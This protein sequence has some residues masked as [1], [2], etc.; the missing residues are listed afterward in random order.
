[1]KKLALFVLLA[2]SPAF[3]QIGPEPTGQIGTLPASY[4]GHWV[5]LQDGAFFHMNNGKIIVVDAD[6]DDPAT[7][8]K[9]MFDASFIAQM[10]Q[11]RT[12][13][14]IYIAE[15]FYSRGT[16]GERTDV[17]TIYDKVNLSPSG[18]VVIPPKRISGMPTYYHLQAVDNERLLLAYNFTPA[19][20]V[21]VVDIDS[22]EFLGEIPIPGCSLI[23][24]MA[25]RAFASLC[26]DG[27]MMSVQL[28]EN[29]AQASSART[30]VFFDANND[31]LMEKAA[32][33]DSVAY[34]PSF[35]GRVVPV[36]LSGDEP[37]VG[38]EWSLIGDEEGGWR[39]GGLAVTGTDA[40]GRMYVLMHPEGYEGS[41]K[42]PGVE[43]WVFDVGSRQRVD[44]IALDLPAISIGITQ[45]DDPLLLAT[46]INLEVDVYDVA[47]GAHQRTLSGTGAQTP[48]LLHGG[49]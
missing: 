31:P 16:R 4:P 49:L 9:G 44:R 8:V 40:A 10:Y 37:V 3:G 20:S 13:S 2:A 46:N 25:G 47:S 27:T 24:P 6:S 41:H 39:P 11:A 30:D 29:G 22:R 5:L 36:D 34:F 32:M 17:I 42:D 7:R 14:E 18:E 12:K 1:M 43:V 28:D 48:F 38:D 19:T 26:T 35:L 15:T 33:I 23:Y 45:D 21:S